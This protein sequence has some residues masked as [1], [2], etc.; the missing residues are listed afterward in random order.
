MYNIK[1]LEEEWK[2]YR[3]KKRRPWLILGTL[4]LIAVAGSVVSFR[5]ASFPS[6]LHFNEENKSTTINSQTEKTEQVVYYIDKPLAELAVKKIVPTEDNPMEIGEIAVAEVVKSQKEEHAAPRKKL[7]IQVIDSK[8]KSA[9]REVEKRFRLGHDTDDSL[10]LAKAYY[11]KKKYKQ[12]EYWALQTNKVNDGIEESWLIF[13]KAKAKR[14]QRNE[15]KRILNMYIKKTNSSEAKVLLEK[16][17]K[18]AI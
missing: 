1:A 3:R 7:H 17:K 9:Y 4:F 11:A 6:L 8:K 18:G 5:Y 12:A 2:R 15:A 10:F 13:A 14:G 16:I